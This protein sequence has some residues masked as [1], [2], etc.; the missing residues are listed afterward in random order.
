MKIVKNVLPN[1]NLALLA[2]QNVLLVKEKIDL[3]KHLLVTV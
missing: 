1:V 2:Q 3:F